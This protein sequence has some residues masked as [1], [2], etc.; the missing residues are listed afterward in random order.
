MLVAV[1]GALVIGKGIASAIAARIFNYTSAARMTIWSL[2]LPQVA[3]TLAATLTGFD[4]L[5]PAGERLVDGNILNVVFVLILVTAT[6]G[7]IMT[8]HYAPL[9]LASSTSNAHHEAA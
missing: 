5:N 9:M 4:T 6:A 8:Q 7:P 3:A 2:T 1:V